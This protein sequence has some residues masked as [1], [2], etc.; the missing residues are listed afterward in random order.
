MRVVA[1]SRQP[2]I[3]DRPTATERPPHPHTLTDY[4]A[5]AGTKLGMTEAKG[6]DSLGPEFDLSFRGTRLVNV[7][8]GAS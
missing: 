8:L 6:F 4:T 3:A 7:D 5:C 1:I 2:R